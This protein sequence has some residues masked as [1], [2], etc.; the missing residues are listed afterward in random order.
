M[1]NK[2]NRL[3]VTV[4][5]LIALVMPR[6]AVACAQMPCCQS[7]GTEWSA[8]DC[9]SPEIAAEQDAPAATK[10]TAASFSFVPAATGE[11]LSDSSHLPVGRIQL[12]LEASRP[13]QRHSQRLAIF[14][15]LR[16]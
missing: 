8:P 6:V 10:V 12:V 3:A 15:L 9:C 4:L 16:I 7:D 13:P 11:L 2:V 14:S 5:I 1:R